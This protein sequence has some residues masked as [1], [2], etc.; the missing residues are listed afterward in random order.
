MGSTVESTPTPPPTL[1]VCSTLVFSTL[2]STAP[3]L[4]TLSS[5]M[6]MLRPMATGAM[7]AGA[8]AAMVAGGAAMAVGGASV[9]LRPSPRSSSTVASTP[10]PPP[11][12]LV[13]STLASS[14]LDSTAPALP[15]L[16]SARLMPRPTAT[17][18]TDGTTATLAGG[19]VG[20]AATGATVDT[21]DGA[22][23]TAAGGATAAGNQL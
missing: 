4:P 8:A 16:S 15:T 23:A 5:V 9:R 12:P 2:D 6:L 21:L 14:T 10:T 7:A 11:T 18:A 20:A 13:S 19:A 22:V 17:G 1:L 3:A